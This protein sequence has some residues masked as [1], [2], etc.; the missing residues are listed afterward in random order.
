MEGFY[1]RLRLGDVDDGA[2]HATDQDHAAGGIAAHKVLG[3]ASSEEVSAVNVDVPELAH[4]VDRV[5][6]GLEVLGEAGAGDQV[7][8][9]A[10][11]HDDVVDAALHRLWVGDIRVVRRHLGYPH[12]ARILPPEY[13]YQLNGLLLGLFLCKAKKRSDQHTHLVDRIFLGL[14]L[15]LMGF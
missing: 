10:V 7:V 11:L 15:L 13:I 6:D 14:Y 3:D 8:D 12:G 2:R 4:A 9:L 1:L 5:V